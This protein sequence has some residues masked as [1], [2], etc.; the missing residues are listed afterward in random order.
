M[1]RCGIMLFCGILSTCLGCGGGATDYPD[2]GTVSGT[3]TLGG[4]PVSG[5]SIAFQPSEVGAR[6]S[7][8][9]TDANGYYSLRYSANMDGAKVGEH[10][11]RISTYQEEGPGEG[12]DI[13]PAVPETIPNQYNS[14]STL[15]QTVEQGSNTF[16]FALDA[17]GEI[18]KHEGDSYEDG[19]DE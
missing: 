1:Q 2:M 6:A 4:S 17:E 16:D 13:V 9:V 8:A 5:A 3:V 10:T 12:G 18:D 11:V 7:S 19:D 15:K 14:K